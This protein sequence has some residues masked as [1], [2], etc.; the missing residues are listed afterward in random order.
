MVLPLKQE[1]TIFAVA[2]QLYVHLR[3]ATGRVIDVI[4]LEQDQ[5]YANEI[6][7]FANQSSDEKVQQFAK[8]LQQHI[9]GCQS[10]LKIEDVT[11]ISTPSA[12]INDECFQAEVSH[13]YIG[14]LR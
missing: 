5:H 3:R 10:Q 6:I 12:T 7:K 4:Y 13:H 14:A 9:M 1:A 2:S 8:M 11:L